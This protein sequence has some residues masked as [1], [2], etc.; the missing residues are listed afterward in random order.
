[1]AFLLMMTQSSDGARPGL[2]GLLL[3]QRLEPLGALPQGL[4]IG[5]AAVCVGRRRTGGR[6]PRYALGAEEGG[7][8]SFVIIRRHCSLPLSPAIGNDGMIAI[9]AARRNPVCP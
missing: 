4:A 6:A 5:G 7:D 1:M 8:R 9:R 2:S 3:A